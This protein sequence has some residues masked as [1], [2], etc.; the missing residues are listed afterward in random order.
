MIIL[1]YS[2]DFHL[3][4]KIEPMDGQDSP[5]DLKSIMAYDTKYHATVTFKFCKNEWLIMI[6]SAL[7]CCI[8]IICFSSLIYYM[9]AAPIIDQY[10]EV[11]YIVPTSN[12]SGA[13]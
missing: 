2:K 7:G 8:L 9:V 6:F 4:L 11:K 13:Y 1:K 3:A 5:Y 10:R 12:T